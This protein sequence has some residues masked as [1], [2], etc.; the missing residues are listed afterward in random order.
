[1][2]QSNPPTPRPTDLIY[3]RRSR[4]LEVRFRSGE[5]YRLPAEYLRVF[6]P[7]AEVRG[8]G[9]PMMLVTGKEAVA[10]DRI[11]PVGHYA[12]RLVFDDGHDSGL[13]TWQF[14]FEMGRDFEK[15][16][17]DYKQ[18]VERAASGGV[19]RHPGK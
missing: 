1:M 17:A 16:W 8:H 4:E 15:N 14:L 10:I 9:G 18:R 19:K 13:Y 5:V 12:V 2:T 11:E 7:S 6:S 3:H